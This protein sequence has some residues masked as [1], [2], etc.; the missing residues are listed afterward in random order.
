MSVRHHIYAVRCTRS[1]RSSHVAEKPSR[2][3]NMV[4]F[5][6]AYLVLLASFL[7][8]CRFQADNTPQTSSLPYYDTPLR[9]QLEEVIDFTLNQR[10][11]DTRVHAAWQILHGAL[12][13]GRQFPVQ[14]NDGQI[15][16]AVDYVLAGGKISGWNVQPGDLLPATSQLGLRAILEAGSKTGQGHV[17][18]WFAVL[19][20]CDLQPDQAI[21]VGDHSLTMEDFVS[22][23]QYDVPRNVNE[24]WSWTLIG[25]TSYLPTDARWVARDGDIWS[26][27]RL[28]QAELDKDLA[29]SACGGTHRLIGLT[30][31][32]NHHL[33]QGG[34]L[35]SP[36]Q[37]VD[38]L[39]RRHIDTAKRLQNSDGSFSTNYFERPGRSPDLA[40]DLGATGHTF[41]F[42]TIAMPDSRLDEP[43]VQR[44]ATHLCDLFR[45]TKS[46]DLECGAL[47]HA[48][49]GLVVYQGRLGD[50]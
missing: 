37:E 48:T 31:A 11:L 38:L 15:Q 20:Q 12:A 6:H 46:I 35:E 1:T 26:I 19:A 39:V 7:L 42:L 8:G 10:R 18:Q 47:Y 4:S 16:S 21:Q 3:P 50:S 17:D 40:Q 49:H 23:V 24:E 44:A 2:K 22:Q 45:K 30:M 27:E 28:V 32:L 25:L 33:S 34:N 5:L 36:W 9:E 29:E 13:Y 43:W 14:T 41:E